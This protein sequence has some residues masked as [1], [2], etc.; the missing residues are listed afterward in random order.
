MTKAQ[1]VCVCGKLTLVGR[2]LCRECTNTKRRERYSTDE[3]YRHNLITKTKTNYNPE[4]HKKL[5]HYHRRQ[6]FKVLGGYTCQSCGFDDPRAQQ[7]DH[8]ENDGYQRRK[9]GEL[10][11]ALYRR[12][13][14]TEG[15][16]FQV[17][18]AN[19]NWIKKAEFEGRTLEYYWEE[20]FGDFEPKR[21]D[22][23]CKVNPEEAFSAFT[24]EEPASEVRRRLHVSCTTLRNWWV[25]KFGEDAVKLRARTIQAKAVTKTGHQNKGRPSSTKKAFT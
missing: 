18:C 7:I 6:A 12:V 4:Q 16:G 25:T 21:P 19:C 2:K 22:Q 24:T 14:K 5:Y 3:E 1:M 23:Q 15:K 20:E 17:L 8:I 9:D 13:V 11:Q 10:G